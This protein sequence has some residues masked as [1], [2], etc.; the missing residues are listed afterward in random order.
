MGEDVLKFIDLNRN[1]L[2][3]II[4]LVPVPLF[5]KDQAGQYIDC[6]TAFMKFLSID[7][8]RIVGRTAYDLW[9][10]DEADIFSA[11]D[12]EL[13]ER[14]GL[15]VYETAVTSAEKIRYIVQF[16]KQ[17]FIDSAG[18][19]VGLLGAIFDIT[20]SKR[21]NDLVKKQRDELAHHKVELE[22]MLAR[23]KHLEGI[24]PI[25]MY[26]K[27]IRGNDSSWQAVETYIMEHS[28]AHFSHGICPHC[29]SEHHPDHS[30]EL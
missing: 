30:A 11:Q 20:E 24:I 18:V 15:Q 7:R 17:V 2:D 21:Q 10:K 4:D 8:E 19:V 22:A 28:D 23:V 25:C 13:F 9:N 6:N 12:K 14:G 29:M 27:K 16:H 3:L 1:L 26:C 5:V